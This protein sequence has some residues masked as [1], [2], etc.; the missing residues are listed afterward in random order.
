[1]KKSPTK[2]Q[3][4]MFYTLSATKMLLGKYAV[5]WAFLF[6]FLCMLICVISYCIGY[7]RGA[8]ESWAKSYALYQTQINQ[9]EEMFWIQ[10]AIYANR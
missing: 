4:T 6:T 7:S 5:G 1:M 8:E 2:E 3:K 10:R 9:L